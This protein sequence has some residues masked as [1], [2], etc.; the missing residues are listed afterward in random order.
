[1]GNAGVN[2]GDESFWG[3]DLGY[4]VAAQTEPELEPEPEYTNTMEM[5]SN[6]YMLQLRGT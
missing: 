2:K 4:S 5:D 3:T 6:L 1:M